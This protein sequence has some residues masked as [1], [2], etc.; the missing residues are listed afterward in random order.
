MDYMFND[1]NQHSLS[2]AP[3]HYMQFGS[4]LQCVLQR[5]VH[6][7]PNH[8]P[9]LMMKLDLADGYYRIP[10]SP[11]AA[12]ELTVLLPSDDNSPPPLIG[13][14]LSLLPMGWRLSPPY[15]CA[16]TETVADIAN[17]TLTNALPPHPLEHVAQITQFP[18]TL[19]FTDTALPPTNLINLQE[20]TAHVDVYIDD[21]IALAQEHATTSTARALFH[22]IDSIFHDQ[23]ASL[24]RQVV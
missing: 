4:T 15:F 1:V 17:V 18:E 20:P 5:I 19:A 3:E 6:A 10:L 2:L 16:F 23:P 11:E 9:P 24:C 13:V 12:L 21:F 8:G 14:P 22:A 7:N